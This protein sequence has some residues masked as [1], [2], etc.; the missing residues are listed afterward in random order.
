MDWHCGSTIAVIVLSLLGTRSLWR[1]CDF[2]RG[3][4][5]FGT[6]YLQPSLCNAASFWPAIGFPPLDAAIRRIRACSQF[7]PG[8]PSP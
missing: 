2:E 5:S 3:L 7:F 1:T 6:T 4:Q 8:A